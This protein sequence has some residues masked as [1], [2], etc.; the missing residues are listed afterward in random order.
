MLCP[1]R[2]EDKGVTWQAIM[3]RDVQNFSPMRTQGRY[4][5]AIGVDPL[6]A[7]KI[8]LG[9]VELW[10]WDGDRHRHTGE[11]FSTFSPN[12]VHA[13]KHV[14]TYDPNNPRVLYIGSDGGVSKSTDGGE[15]FLV[16]NKGYQSTQFYSVAFTPEYGLAFGGTQDNG[17]NGVLNNNPN[18]RFFGFEVFTHDGFDCE[19]SQYFPLLFASSQRSLV[20]RLDASD[21]NQTPLPRKEI[22]VPYT[23]GNFLPNGA[24]PFHTVIRLWESI[25]DPTSKDTLEFTADLER[26]TILRNND[27]QR[28]F[29]QTLSPFQS[30][31]IPME[32]TLVLKAGNQVILTE[33]AGELTGAGT[34]TVEYPGD[35]TVKV[36]FTL[37]DFYAESI[38]F[39]AEFD[40]RYAANS[41]LKLTS[42]TGGYEFDFRLESNL[43][44]GQTVRVQDPVQSLFMVNFATENE[45]EV[46][47]NSLALSRNALRVD[48]EAEWI[49]ID[50]LGQITCAEFSE[51]GNTM[52]VG[53]G[54]LFIETLPNTARGRVLRITGLNDLYSE[55]DVEDLEITEIFNNE[56]TVTGISLDPN[57][58][59]RLVVTLGNYGRED[60]VYYTR[61]ALREDALPLFRN[62]QSNLPPMPVY[63]AEIDANDPNI[64]LL[65]TDFGIW[66]T[67]N[68][69]ETD[70][71]DVVW[72]DEN[73]GS[74][75][76]TYLP[77]FDVRQQRQGFGESN[78]FY[79]YYFGTH[80]R[81][82]WKTRSLVALG[83]DDVPQ[84]KIEASLSDLQLAPN[85]VNGQGVINV[86]ADGYE[87]AQLTVIDLQGRLIAERY[88][89]LQPGA[90]QLPVDVYGWPNGL[91]IASLK[92]PQSLRSIRMVVANE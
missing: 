64:V 73:G 27:L 58:A 51:D 71:D 70:P 80:G 55:D 84:P 36:D 59:D 12:Y 6:D 22:S 5:L 8:F 78:N 35:G 24:G 33:Q 81:G 79:Q 74:G 4:N 15:T 11:G 25:D 7:G 14:F 85:P 9:G 43:E 91:Y 62:V 41:D 45:N 86:T 46:V 10:Q 90:N 77:V 68:I 17:T 52:F 37:D 21:P 92:T 65:G 69:D 75:G 34:G 88:V 50:N 26:V 89:R 44:P 20:V 82:I 56:K 30:A 2:S 42:L 13:D 31:A 61:E 66:S 47:T 72:S 53:I 57:N 19:S 76:L 67:D 28:E 49:E 87:S 29:S 40:V 18:D 1:Y 38:V 60:H 63:D 3:V 83:D 54:P 16:V 48:K 23:N 39:K 32:G